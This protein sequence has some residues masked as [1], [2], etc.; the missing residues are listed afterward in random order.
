MESDHRIPGLLSWLSACIFISGLWQR[1]CI[2]SPQVPQTL[3]S[4]LLLFQKFQVMVYVCFISSAWWSRFSVFW[5]HLP[6]PYW[7]PNTDSLLEV[8]SIYLRQNKAWISVSVQVSRPSPHLG[9]S[10]SL[11]L[12]Q[13]NLFFKSSSRPVLPSVKSWM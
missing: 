9:H 12:V 11:T 6:Y 8:R 10:F 1:H 4:S 13:A 2:T 7:I 5:L 3:V